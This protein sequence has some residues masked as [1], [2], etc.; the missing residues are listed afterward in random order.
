MLGDSAVD[1]CA[2]GKARLCLCSKAPWLVG[3]GDGWAAA[4][5]PTQH[6]HYQELF[7]F[8]ALLP[9]W[10]PLCSL[11]NI[12]LNCCCLEIYYIYYIRIILLYCLLTL[13]RGSSGLFL[14]FW[15]PT[16]AEGKRTLDVGTYGVT[17]PWSGIANLWA[18]ITDP[19]FSA[20]IMLNYPRK[21]SLHI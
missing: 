7:V 14:F 9:L 1:R 3:H 10:F 16:T 11:R 4:E 12:L 15:S 19:W 6:H 20:W 21:H 8:Q 5:I 13:S 17:W 18:Y 2:L